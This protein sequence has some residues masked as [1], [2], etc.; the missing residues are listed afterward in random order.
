MYVAVAD[1][2]RA[3]EFYSKLFRKSPS[4]SSAH[5]TEFELNAMKFGVLN[6]SQ[7]AHPLVRGNSCVPTF[8]VTSI[9]FEHARMQRL[10]EKVG[11]IRAVGDYT[12]FEFTDPD[13]N[14]LECLM[15]SDKCLVGP[16]KAATM[17]QH[18]ANKAV[19]D[20]FEDYVGRVYGVKAEEL[21]PRTKGAGGHIHFSAEEF[22]ARLSA[23]FRE[24][25]L[26]PKDGL[27]TYLEIE[28][29]ISNPLLHWDETDIAMLKLLRR[30][31]HLVIELSDDEKERID[32]GISI[33][34]VEALSNG[35]GDKIEA[36]KSKLEADPNNN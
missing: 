28:R 10:S 8:E 5:Y 25:D 17:T 36:F 35:I 30:Y 21:V 4:A 29:A 22:G 11:E 9:E 33:H 19:D 20:W 18:A 2:T 23:R 14:V 27:V 12:L 13:G 6:Q 32:S 3:V 34:D 24:L 16:K 31:Y 7:Y 1:M 26:V 15:A